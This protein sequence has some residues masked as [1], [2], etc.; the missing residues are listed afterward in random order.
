MKSKYQ[1]NQLRMDLIGKKNYGYKK[2]Q[3]MKKEK[4]K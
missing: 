1:S 4:E 2:P 3:I